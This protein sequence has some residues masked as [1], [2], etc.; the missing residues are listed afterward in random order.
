MG[1][2]SQNMAARTGDPDPR[3]RLVEEA[4]IMTPGAEPSI[5]QLLGNL[6]ADGQILVRKEFELA[7]QE[8]SL[9]IDKVRQGAISL[10]I[11]IGIVSVG[12]LFLLL[13]LAHGLAALFNIPL[14]LGYLIVG[15]VMAIIGGVL[16]VT[17][18]N[19]LKQ[20]D[21]IPHETIDSVRKDVTWLKEQS[22]SD[23]T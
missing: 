4:S 10:G 8:I 2:L 11:G 9:E 6:I 19:R 5:A 16:L 14:G 22:P 12:S 13:A 1:N 21:P 7:R 17:G 15:L 3:E 23:K 18:S 20:V